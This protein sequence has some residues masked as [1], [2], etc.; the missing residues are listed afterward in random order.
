MTHNEKKENG[1]DRIESTWVKCVQWAKC[2]KYDQD[3]VSLG[4]TV[5]SV[6]RL[7]QTHTLERH[8]CVSGNSIEPTRSWDRSLNVN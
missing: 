2:V 5:P 3:L 1:L 7:T 4:S 8:I 6:N